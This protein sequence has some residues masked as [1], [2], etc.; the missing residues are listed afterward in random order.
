MNTIYMPKWDFSGVLM[1]RQLFY[2][3]VISLTLSA[4]S[5]VDSKRAQ[6]DFDYA[7][8]QESKEFVVPENLDKPT[9]NQQFA[10]TSIANTQG[11]VG[12]EMDIRA[13]S[14]VLPLADSSRTI[15]ESA[16]PI[17]WFDKVLEDKDLLTF[18]KDA[19]IG[20]LTSDDVS[21]NIVSLILKRDEVRRDN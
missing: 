12:E 13:P 11:P 18:V 3:S 17:I 16:D 14:L 19:L 6:G 1:N 21:Y 15:P 8:K 9:K 20:Q 7:K 2:F 10:I 4:C 5:S